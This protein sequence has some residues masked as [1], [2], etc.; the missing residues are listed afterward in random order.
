MTCTVRFCHDALGNSR[1]IAGIRSLCASE[2]TDVGVSMSRSLILLN[3]SVC[4]ASDSSAISFIAGIS[5]R[6]TSLTL[7]ITNTAI[8]TILLRGCGQKVGLN[9]NRQ[10]ERKRCI[11]KN[12]ITELL[13]YI[14][15]AAMCRCFTLCETVQKV[16]DKLYYGKHNCRKTYIRQ[17]ALAPMMQ[18]KERARG[19]LKEGQPASSK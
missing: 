7:H 9:M 1:L 8:L 2:I 18:P 17:C 13:Q 14:K 4:D 16:A 3:T 5:L 12:S 6:P 15:L 10:K 19:N 11:Q